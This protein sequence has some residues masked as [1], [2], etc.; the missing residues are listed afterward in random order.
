MNDASAARRLNF[1]DAAL[2]IFLQWRSNLQ[3]GALRQLALKS[4]DLQ[5]DKHYNY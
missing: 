1:L 4:A 2:A 5:R 3:F